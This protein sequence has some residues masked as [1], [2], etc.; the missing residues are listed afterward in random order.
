MASRGSPWLS[1]ALLVVLTEGVYL[2]PSVLSG[3]LL[4]LDYSQLHARHIAFAREALLGAG[5]YLPGWYPRELLGAPFAANIQSFPWIPTR[6]MLLLF[7]PKF[8]YELGVALAAA[9]ASVFTYLFCKRSGLSDLG[10][11]TAG[12]TFACAGFFASRVMAGHLPMLEA[13]PALPLLLWLA[14]RA[15]A[16][17]RARFQ[18]RDLAA[19]ALAAACVALAGHPQLPV[20][21]LAAAV[22]YLI[23]RGGG[24]PLILAVS[25]LALGLGLALFALYPMMLLIQ[26]STRVLPLAP[27]ANDI[28]MP[29][30][31]LLALIWPGRDGWPGILDLSSENLFHGY[32]N[33]A[34]FWDTVSYIG[35]LPLFAILL[36]LA[37]A[38]TNKRAPAAPFAFL[39]ALGIGALVLSLPVAQPVYR[40]IPGTFLR[41]PSR[42]LYLCTFSAS[43]ALGCAVSWFMAS[44]WFSVRVRQIILLACLV[45]H[46]ADLGGFTRLFVQPADEEDFPRPFAEILDRELDGSRIASEDMSHHGRYDDAGIFDSILLA[47]PYRALLGLAGLPRN[48]NEQVIDA[49]TFPLPALEAGGVRFVITS[50]TRRDLELVYSTE[51]GNLYRVRDPFPRA[52]FFSGG[53]IDFGFSNAILDRFIAEPRRDKLLLPLDAERTYTPEPLPDLLESKT[54][55]IRVIYSRPS[56]D[57]IHI[58]TRPERPGFVAVLE[59]YDP[60]WKASLDGVAAPVVMAN[61]FSMAVPVTPGQHAI[62]LRY[63]TPGR[64]LGILLSLASAVL[65]ASLLAIV[66]LVIL[67][68]PEK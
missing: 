57:E 58:E 17:D 65:L 55:P 60:G 49:A 10:A 12:W 2:R 19:L 6:L 50:E 39:T 61:G 59:S 37:R 68:Q 25:S 36:L 62:V 42:L 52:A 26:R 67:N 20:Y 66:R 29:Y 43:V 1:I 51:Q 23:L 35:L 38:F 21:S 32:P 31:R 54:N 18:V 53:Q 9:L 5:H 63:Y 13:Y 47:N 56:S 11:V 30:G 16:A 15:V 33:G 40:L 45:G 3:G 22:V 8:A 14:D 41:S 34:Y 4:G 28:A 27:A 7:D 64:R 24:R 48:L 44:G 46:A